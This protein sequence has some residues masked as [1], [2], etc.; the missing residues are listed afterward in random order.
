MS[1]LVVMSFQV[2]CLK[3]WHCRHIANSRS[4]SQMRSLAYSASMDSASWGFSEVLLFHRGTSLFRDEEMRSP[5]LCLSS[6]PCSRS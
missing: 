2:A 3:R 5:E 1:S 4:S 6:F